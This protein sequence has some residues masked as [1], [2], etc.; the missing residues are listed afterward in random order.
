[1]GAWRARRAATTSTRRWILERLGLGLRGAEAFEGRLEALAAALPERDWI[2]INERLV[3]FG[4]FVCTG[5]RP[6]CGS[7]LLARQC[8]QVGVTAPRGA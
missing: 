6:R 7:C 8:R 3:P 2:E 5:E 1:M 4:K